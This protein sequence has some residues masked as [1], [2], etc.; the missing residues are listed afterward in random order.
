[1][2]ILCFPPFGPWLTVF[3]AGGANG[4]SIKVHLRCQH[5][6]EAC[7]DS[8]SCSPQIYQYPKLGVA[9]LSQQLCC[10]TYYF[11][12]YHIH[13]ELAHLLFSLS[14][15]LFFKTIIHLIL[16]PFSSL[17]ICLSPPHSGLP[18]SPH[19]TQGFPCPI[20]S[21]SLCPALYF[22]IAFTPLD[23]VCLFL[24][25]FYAHMNSLF[26]GTFSCQW[27]I[28]RCLACKRCAKIICWT[29][30]FSPPNYTIVS[31]NVPWS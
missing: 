15:S 23:K 3:F 21:L 17:L 24:I 18:R 11:L 20:Y 4:P 22:S 29:R 13:T 1:M 12:L 30:E 25:V 27:C 28:T 5:L 31:I 6:Q 26:T 10:I 2:H 8:L 9:S 16:T 19:L 7:L 14:R